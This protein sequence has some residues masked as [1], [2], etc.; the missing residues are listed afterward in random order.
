[1][2]KFATFAYNNSVH[3]TTGYT[4]HELAHGFQIKISSMLTKPKQT[5]N[6]ENYADMVRNNI[7]KAMELVREHLIS[8]KTKNKGYYDAK[9]KDLNIRIDDWVLI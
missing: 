6:Y 8:R 4:S 7:A 1:M 5:Y 3:A 9:V 2:S